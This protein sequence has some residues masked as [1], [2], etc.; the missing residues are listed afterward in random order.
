[1]PLQKKL[2]CVRYRR[3]SRKPAPHGRRTTRQYTR[4]ERRIGRMQPERVE[5]VAFLRD[6][7]GQRRPAKG[8]WQDE[9]T[10]RQS[11]ANCPQPRRPRQHCAHTEDL[12]ARAEA[13]AR[14]AALRART[15]PRR[16]VRRSEAGG[17]GGITPQGALPPPPPEASATE[18]LV[19]QATALQLLSSELKGLVEARDE[20]HRLLALACSE[21]DFEKA[22]ARKHLWLHIKLSFFLGPI[23]GA[24]V[25]SPPGAPPS[26]TPPSAASTAAA[27]EDV[28]PS[29]E[30]KTSFFASISAPVR[31]FRMKF[32]CPDFPTDP[33][34]C[35]S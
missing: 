31:S 18:V 19:V 3:R 20:A 30:G 25:V 29:N 14:V 35:G 4:R 28:E 5:P 22:L 16:R 15:G 11:P 33:A 1:M 26:A 21:A 13:H 24:A 10:A 23:P 6:S 9:R 8:S 34:Q 27:A 7:P 2:R 32:V 12:A 17:E